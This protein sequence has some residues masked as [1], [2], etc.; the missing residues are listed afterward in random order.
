MKTFARVFCHHM[1][2]LR[3]VADVRNWSEV[4]AKFSDLSCKVSSWSPLSSNLPTLSLITS[5]TSAICT[6]TSFI[7]SVANRTVFFEDGPL[8]KKSSSSSPSSLF[9]SLSTSSLSALS[10]SSA[11]K[12]LFGGILILWCFMDVLVKL[13]RKLATY[14]HCKHQH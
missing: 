4:V 13:E 2:R 12:F 9:M 1:L 14:K 11:V 3:R 5:V 7:L 8:R 6:R 10:T